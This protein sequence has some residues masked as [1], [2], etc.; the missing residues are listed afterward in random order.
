MR[1]E[2]AGQPGDD[3]RPIG[4]VQQDFVIPADGQQ[5]SIR[6]IGHR[7][8]HR[9]NRVQR[10]INLRLARLGRV[11]RRAGG[12]PSRDQRNLLALQRIALVGHIGVFTGDHFEQLAFVRL[13]RHH[14]RAVLAALEQHCNR[15]HVQIAFELFRLVAGIAV[16]DEDRPNVAVK[17]DRL[18][19]GQRRGA[20]GNN[21]N[22]RKIG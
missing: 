8:H 17:A 7:R 4:F 6:R 16:G 9:R 3:L 15:R 12:D 1:G 20:Q 22:Q 14:V 13:A 21:Q 2:F 11:I 18:I 19:L 10:R 5:R